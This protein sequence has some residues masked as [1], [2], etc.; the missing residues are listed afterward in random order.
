MIPGPTPLL[1]K[2][3]SCIRG[4]FSVYVY[5]LN[6]NVNQGIRVLWFEAQPTYSLLLATFFNWDTHII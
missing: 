5:E 3:K 1:A 4:R 6:V 2:K